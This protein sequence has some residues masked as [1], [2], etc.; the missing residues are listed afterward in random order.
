[1]R[2]HFTSE[3]ITKQ[4]A[5]IDLKPSIK[6]KATFA[7]QVGVAVADEVQA[8]LD[9]TFDVSSDKERA[10]LF[11]FKIEFEHAREDF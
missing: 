5:S 11:S 3:V 1:M 6:S 10:R 8:T 7:T 2:L 4:T 9:S